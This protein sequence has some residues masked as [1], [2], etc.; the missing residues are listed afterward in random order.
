MKG[1]QPCVLERFVD[2]AC[3]VSVIVA[4]NE[5]GETATWPVAENRASRRHPRRV[6]RSGARLDDAR[7]ATRATL[8]RASPR[9][10][11]T[12]AC[13]ASRCSS[14][15][16]GRAARQRDRAA[17]AQQRPLHDRRLRDVAVRAA[18]ARARRPAARAIT[19][20]HTPAV[21]VNLLGDIWFDG[22]D[23]RCRAS[24]RGR[25]VLAASAREAASL[26]QGGGAARAQD[27]PRDLPRRHARRRAR[28]RARVK[29]TLS[30]PGADDTARCGI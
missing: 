20:Q 3:E 13:C 4:R 30:I 11:T 12:A 17:A 18:G 27:G 21:M 14:P 22:P 8:R 5:H 28:R 10:S 19:R 23:R 6:D 1:S 25:E 2:L 9:R 26:R 7:P 16:D 29:R 24:P 15:H